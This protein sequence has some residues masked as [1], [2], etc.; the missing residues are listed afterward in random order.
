MP[1]LQF[2]YDAL[3]NRVA[4]IEKPR[5]QTT[6]QLLPAADWVTTFYLRDAQGNVISVY[7]QK[8]VNQTAS[9]KQIRKTRLRR[10][11]GND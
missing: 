2:N 6:G 9:Y 7:K 10:Y 11:F 4:K 3:G 5:N 1:D 8:A